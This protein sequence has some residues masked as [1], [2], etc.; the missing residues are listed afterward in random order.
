MEATEEFI[1]RKDG[2]T[3]TAS[4]PFNSKNPGQS[5]ESEL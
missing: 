4:L 5:E 2:G 3:I 1:C